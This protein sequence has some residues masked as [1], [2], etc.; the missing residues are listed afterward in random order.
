MNNRDKQRN[1]IIISAVLLL[2]IGIANYINYYAPPKPIGKILSFSSLSEKEQQQ[3]FEKAKKENNN[4]ETNI[5]ED[6]NSVSKVDVSESELKQDNYLN[7]AIDSNGKLVRWNKKKI[8]VF[9]SESEYKNT[10]YKALS[11][12]NSTFEKYFTFY[13]AKDRENSDIK[14]DVVNHFSSNDNKDSIYMAGITNNSFSGS[15]KHLTNSHIQILSKKPNS[16]KKITDSEVYRVVLHEL[17]HALGIIGHSPNNNDVMFAS[18]SVNKLSLRDI[19]TIKL[20]YSGNQSLIK[21]ETKNFADTKLK[22]AEDYAKKSPNKAISWVNL[23]R[24]Y[25]DLG[26]KEDALGAYKKALAI[27]PKNPLI[28]QSMAECYYSS[29]KYDVAIKYY[30]IAL[31]NISTDEQKAPIYNMIGMCYAKQDKFE[32]AYQYFK[33]AYEIDSNNRMLLKNYLVA[34]V[35]LEKKQ[36]AITAINNYKSKFPDILNEDFVK[37]VIKWAK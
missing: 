27:E 32:N 3:L 6:E 36:E 33:Q 28:Y 17:G 15:D 11:T 21:S 1:L 12:Y 2:T 20:M 29:L 24:V 7:Y 14:I 22:E 5:Q 34:C 31:E 25:Y 30:N 16:N 26:K 35:E 19:A 18:E 8:T 37:D 13:L 10:I 4:I 23:G 9:V